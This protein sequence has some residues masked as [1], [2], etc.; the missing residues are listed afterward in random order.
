MRLLGSRKTCSEVRAT[1]LDQF[2]TTW[3]LL[4]QLFEKN[5]FD[6]FSSFRSRFLASNQAF[7]YKT[8]HTGT[9]KIDFSNSRPHIKNSSGKISDM[10]MNFGPLALLDPIRRIDKYFVV[11]PSV[12]KRVFRPFTKVKSKKSILRSKFRFFKNISK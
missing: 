3:S 7:L 5:F 1:L 11:T 9:S 4:E 12:K 6:I 10:V 2:R 8:E